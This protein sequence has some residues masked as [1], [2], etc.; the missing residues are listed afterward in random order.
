MNIWQ[1]ILCIQRLWQ[2]Y[3]QLWKLT[4]TCTCILCKIVI[5]RVWAALAMVQSEGQTQ[6]QYPV[7]KTYRDISWNA[8]EFWLYKNTICR[9]W[10]LGPV[11][12]CQFLKKNNSKEGKKYNCDIINRW[13]FMQQINEE[14][15]NI[16]FTGQ[17]FRLNNFHC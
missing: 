7:F 14:S 15:Q 2:S 3:K 11:Q 9:Q 4:R 10:P 16:S 12:L 5:Q 8:A 17:Y 6:R 13:C 1:K